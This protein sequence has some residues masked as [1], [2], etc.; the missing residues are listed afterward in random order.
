[1]LKAEVKQSHETL[2]SDV[3]WLSNLLA[4]GRDPDISYIHQTRLTDRAD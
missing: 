2:Q 3:L 1:M 4:D